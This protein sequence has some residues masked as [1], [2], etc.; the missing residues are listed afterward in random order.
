MAA[1]SAKCVSGVD[2]F[3]A[4]GADVPNVIFDDIQI[5]RADRSG[6]VLRQFFFLFR[7]DS[8]HTRTVGTGGKVLVIVFK[9]REKEQVE[10]IMPAA[11][12][13]VGR[14]AARRH[15]TA[16]FTVYSSTLELMPNTPIKT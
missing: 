12:M 15:S 3:T 4:E 5:L 16:L 8:H 7:V 14:S 1:F 9:N 2:L 11:D 13:E 6:F 10:I